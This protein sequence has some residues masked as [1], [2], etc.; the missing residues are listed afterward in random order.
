MSE[1]LRT[2]SALS[3]QDLMAEP[4][5]R[6]LENWTGR[7][8]ADRFEI[9]DIDPA[10]S[11]TEAF[12]GHYGVDPGVAANTVIVEAKRGS[13]S[14]LAAVVMLAAGRADLN[15]VVR[16]A[17]RARRLSLAPKDLAIQKSGMEFGSI[18]AIGLPSDWQLMVDARAAVI[19]KLLMGGGLR[20][21]KLLFPGQALLELPNARVIENMVKIDG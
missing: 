16:K 11:D 18:T 19:P 17:L 4:V 2:F 21:S 13:E 12:C 3:R 14:H 9:A 20:R 7:V 1:L 8:P 6:V 10:F 15:G 5:W